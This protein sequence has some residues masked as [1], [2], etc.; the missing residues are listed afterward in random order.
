MQSLYREQ[1]ADI[2]SHEKESDWTW[3]GEESD[4]KDRKY[5]DVD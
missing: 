1:T 4:W 5:K 3:F 2:A